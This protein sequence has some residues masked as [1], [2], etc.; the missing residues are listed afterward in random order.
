MKKKAFV[1]IRLLILII[2]T[3]IVITIS[4]IVVQI[5]GNLT[6]KDGPMPSDSLWYCRELQIQ[7]SFIPNYTPH[8]SIEEY[9]TH[10]YIIT[11]DECIMCSMYLPVRGS[12]GLSVY[13]Q[14]FDHMDILGKKFFQGQCLSVD[15]TCYTIRG[16]NGVEYQFLKI[17][18]FS[19]KPYLD[20]Y[21]NHIDKLQQKRGEP[22]HIEI[23]T[24]YAI[25]LWKNQFGLNDSVE[26]ETLNVAY[27]P[28]HFYWLVSLLY[29][30][31]VYFALISENGD[32][33]S[34]W[35]E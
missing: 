15:D 33:A 3:I 27:D 10:T 25:D 2:M 20:N 7:L 29:S 1:R 6:A 17:D 18:D 9:E 14:D 22:K 13:A 12:V 32:F 28:I 31:S 21:D 8:S 23:A 11:D 4:L 26:W 24:G 35:T 19:A 34:V 30:D 5:Y 16:N